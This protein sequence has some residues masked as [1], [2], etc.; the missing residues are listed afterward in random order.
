MGAYLSSPVTGKE[1]YEGA[2][3]GYLEY[4]GASMQVSDV[5]AAQGCA[6]AWIAFSSGGR[7]R[8]ALRWRPCLAAARELQGSAREAETHVCS[9][10]FFNV[11]GIRANALSA[12]RC[13]SWHSLLSSVQLPAL[14]LT[15]TSLE[16]DQGFLATIQRSRWAAAA[17]HSSLSAISERRYDMPACWWVSH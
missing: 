7:R 3:E 1:L 11:P 10:Q 17:R 4:G 2:K 15:C 5:P 6:A 12:G 16:P 8:L 13:G 14:H 9:V